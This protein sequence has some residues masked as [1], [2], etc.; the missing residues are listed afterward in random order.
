MSQLRFYKTKTSMVF[1]LVLADNTILS[2]FF[3]FSLMI[4]WHKLLILL[5]N[6]QCLQ[7]HQLMKQIQ[8]FKHNRWMQKQKYENVQSNLNSYILFYAFHSLCF[9]LT[10]NMLCVMDLSLILYNT[11]WGLYPI[12]KES[13]FTSVFLSI[14]NET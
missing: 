1:K 9:S 14:N 2:C 11:S 3:F 6:L 13:K 7:K 10:L 12:K 5:Q 4:E 8:K